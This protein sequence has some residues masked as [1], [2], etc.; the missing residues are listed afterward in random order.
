MYFVS[1]IAVIVVIISLQYQT[2][3]SVQTQTILIVAIVVYLN[4]PTTLVIH[5]VVTHIVAVVQQGIVYI[6]E[7]I[8]VVQY[9]AQ[10]TT[11]QHTV[12]QRLYTAYPLHNCGAS[13]TAVAYQGIPIVLAQQRIVVYFSKT[14]VDEGLELKMKGLI[15][16]IYRI[17]WCVTSR[18]RCICMAIVPSNFVI[19][20]TKPVYKPLFSTIGNTG[21][22]WCIY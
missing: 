12:Y 3:T 7:N 17:V 14:V 15:Q 8:V 6:V 2:Q 16:P 5:I 21:S 9:T 20:A 4:Q 10:Q 13:P 19:Y 22:L 11:A 1:Q 18:L